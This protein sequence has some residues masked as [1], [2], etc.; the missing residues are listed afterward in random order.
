MNE[1]GVPRKRKY[2]LKR[3]AEKQADTRRRIVEATFALHST[4]GPAR[5]TVSDISRRAGVQRATFYR[6]F[7]DELSLFKECKAFG[8]AEYPLPDLSACASVA[9]PVQRLR[10]GLATAY[11]Y[12]REHEQ[13]MAMIIRD[14]EV[15]PAG[16]NY[17]RFQDQLRDVLA[18]AWEARGQRK[19][20]IV[21]ACG[22]AADFQ[23]WR[24]LARKQ[25][26]SDRQVI[27]SM[28]ALVRA[29]AGQT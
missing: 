9:D 22:H 29:A 15:M 12:Y 3:R 20:R 13:Q 23:A 8:A 25:G 21:A 10:S 26:L 11:A 28:V 19:V 7:P 14:S 27:E 2:D 16:G 1:Q 24:S 4:L 18:A 6:H 17:F 5:T